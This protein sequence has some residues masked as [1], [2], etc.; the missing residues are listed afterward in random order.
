MYLS[1]RRRAFTLIELL[2]VIAIIGILIAML[3]PA[4]QK[5][6]E[7]ANRTTCQNNLHQLAI[8]AHNYHDVKRALP[9]SNGIPPTSALGGFTPPNK[10]TGIWQDPRFSGL[11]WGTFSWSAYILPYIEGNTVYNIIDFN[12]PAYTP[13]FE[14][15]GGN[16]RTPLKG[17][18]NAGVATAGA[19][20]GGYG[21]LVNKEAALSMPS[22]FIYPS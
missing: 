12:Y 3:V 11:P 17:L 1:V 18:Y 5:V 6:R 10:F 9:P 19:G 14:E 16:P 15:Y 8:A 2:V 13:E 21:D 7:A 20:L 4:V 22:V